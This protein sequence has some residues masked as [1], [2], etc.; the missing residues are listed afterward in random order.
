MLLFGRKLLLHIEHG[1]RTG[2]K[3]QWEEM[4]ERPG[5]G[6]LFNQGGFQCRAECVTIKKAN[7]I[8]SIHR[9]GA[10]G[11]RDPHARRAERPNKFDY[12]LI[13]AKIPTS[14]PRKRL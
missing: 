9:V 2:I 10:L 8:C 11:Y 7:V 13:H 4:L 5:V 3:E 6:F 12:S 14:N 1:R